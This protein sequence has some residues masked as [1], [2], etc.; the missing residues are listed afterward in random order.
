MAKHRND[1]F[2]L[3][4]QQVSFCTQASNLLTEILS[5]YSMETILEEQKK[6]HKIEHQADELRHNIIKKLS[7]EFITPID[8]EDILRLAQIIDDVTDALDEAVTDLYMFHVESVP[9]AAPKLAEKVSGC[10]KALENA[11]HELRNFKKPNKLQL[12]LVEVNRLES[13][14]DTEYVEAIHQLFSKDAHAK[15][16]I[17]SK[18]IYDSLEN[19]CDSCEHAAN[20]IEQTIM[21]NI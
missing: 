2:S 20:V 13:E 6:M 7:R 16:I 1:Y 5:N 12:L 15:E 10:V 9:E 18:A 19:C 14:A 21:K 4:E 3:L 11:V 8:Q 17:G